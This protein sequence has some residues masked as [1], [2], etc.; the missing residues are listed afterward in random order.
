MGLILCILFLLIPFYFQFK[1]GTWSLSGWIKLK[2]WQL[3][4]LC[5]VSEY[6]LSIILFVLLILIFPKENQ[7]ICGFGK[8]G[9]A[10]LGIPLSIGI[11]FIA[12]IQK[13]ALK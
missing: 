10:F 7:F 5:F 12:L 2:F 3:T 6:V 13:I 8:A 1:Y 11:L 4:L 9:I